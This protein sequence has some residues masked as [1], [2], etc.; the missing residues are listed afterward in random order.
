M[1]GVGWSPIAK[2]PL[3][4]ERSLFQAPDAG[5]AVARF[6]GNLI[7]TPWLWV[8]AFGLIGLLALW[9]VVRGPRRPAAVLV[10]TLSLAVV[11]ICAFLP[12]R[13]FLVAWFAA[14]VPLAAMAT[15]WALVA[16]LP[17]RSCHGS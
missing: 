17:W 6:A 9:A 10:V 3:I 12:R 2:A 7:E 1:V 8:E 13:R 5:S 15:L 16:F 14:V 11:L 4:W